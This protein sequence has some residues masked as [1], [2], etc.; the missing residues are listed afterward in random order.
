MPS[1]FVLA[2][3]LI[4]LPCIAQDLPDIKAQRIAQSALGDYVT[5]K[6]AAY[7][8]KEVGRANA[9]GVKIIE[10]S[11]TSQRW[12]DVLWRH[13]LFVLLPEKIDD[14]RQAMLL[15]TG[16]NWR[17]EPK[18]I[19]ADNLKLPK[20]ATMLAGATQQLA[21][22]VVILNNVPFQPMFDDLREDALIAFSFD[23]YLN[24]G[25]RNWPLLLPMVKSAVRAMDAAQ[26]FLREKEDVVV[27]SFTVTGAS[28]RGWTTWLTAAIDPRVTAAAPMVIDMLNLG[29]QI[30]HQVDVWGKPSEQV[31]DY[32]D[33]N[34]LE[35]MDSARG[36]LLQ[37]IVDPYSY[38]DHLLQ[39]KLIFLGS[40]DPYWPV[41][42]SN[43]YWDDIKGEKY[44]TIVPNAGHNLNNDFFRI[45]GG[46]KAIHQRAAHG[47]KLPKLTWDFSNRDGT[48]RLHVTSDP[49]ARDAVA[50]IARCN[51]RDF[52][53]AR[54]QMTRM[55][56]REG[57]Y[58]LSLTPAAGEF[59]GIF[60]DLTFEGSPPLHLSTNVRIVSAG[61]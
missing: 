4:C 45:V 2:L 26:S 25:D 52:R 59:V 58:E 50:W 51:S 17:G 23:K 27:D 54:W 47:E 3:C 44:L 11:L 18:P 61:E 9:L 21:C 53:D 29:V 8:W 20:E 34:I 16:G 36:K 43:L 37:A 10:L 49:P 56:S 7:S 30:K 5:A 32:T 1:R 60:G 22:P 14:S 38:L 19:V 46:L 28:K 15:I 12:Q 24:G 31:H 57:G 33:R 41:D 42:A 39:P 13:R 48:H 35:R 40:N 6:D 55:E